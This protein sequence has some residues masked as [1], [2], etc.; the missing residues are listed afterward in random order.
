MAPF[1]S[2][3]TVSYSHFIATIA[4]IIFSHLSDNEI[5]LGTY[6]IL[7]GVISNDLE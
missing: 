1:D 6:A 4:V 2:F 3:G 7:K 5:L